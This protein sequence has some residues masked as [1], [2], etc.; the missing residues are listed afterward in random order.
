[1]LELLLYLGPLVSGGIQLFKNNMAD[2]YIRRNGY[3]ITEDN[4]TSTEKISS[5]IKD[6]IY[7]LVPFYNYYKAYQLF[8][9]DDRQYINKRK[10]KLD[11]YERLKVIENE[12]EKKKEVK[13]EVKKQEKNNEVNLLEKQSKKRSISNDINELIDEIS[14]SDD[15]G[16]LYQ[17]KFEYKTRGNNLRKEYNDK[18]SNGAAKTELN[19]IVKKVMIYDK[20][21]IQARD[22]LEVVKAKSTSMYR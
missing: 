5:F 2:N 1:M 12:E 13:K 21:F 22:R 17:I 16:F 10:N 11:I 18:K 9:L 20:V 4:R 3:N 14:H 19:S 15:I 7:I 6:Y 8:T